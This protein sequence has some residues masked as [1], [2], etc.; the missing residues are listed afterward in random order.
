MKNMIINLRFA[1]VSATLLLTLSTNLLIAKVNDSLVV[2]EWGTFTTLSSSNGTLL[3]GVYKDAT[4]LPAFVY[5]LPNLNYDANKGWPAPDKLLHVTVKMETPVLYFYSPS[6][7]NIQVRVKFMGGSI[8]QWYPQRDTGEVNPTQ[9]PFNMTNAYIGN[10]AWKAKI[11]APSAT[12]SLTPPLSQL[13]SEWTSPRATTSNLLRNNNGEVEKFLFYRGLGSFSSSLKIFF[14]PEGNLSVTNIGKWKINHVMVYE[15]P[16][17]AT[18]M[19]MLPPKIWWE[20]SLDSTQKIILR[21]TNDSGSWNTASAS[22]NKLRQKM[23][24][25]GLFLDEANALFSTWEQSYFSSEKGLKVFWIVPREEVDQ[26]LPLNIMPTPTKLERVIIGRT[27]IITPEFEAQLHTAQKKDSLFKYADDKYYFAYLNYLGANI[28]T[29]LIP[30]SIYSSSPRNGLSLGFSLPNS[31]SKGPVLYNP[32]N[33][34]GNDGVWN[35]HGQKLI[36]SPSKA[37]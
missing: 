30:K 29:S 2:H 7:K 8:S 24:E 33:I 21:K 22:I 37:K 15:L 18:F 5:G 9:T 20:G 10:I 27:E 26:I 31:G 23:V 14:T 4:R 12:D 25:S 19:L 28:G 13:T 36:P 16:N 32:A 11:L 3:S 6:E 1:F 34:W 35:L 17:T